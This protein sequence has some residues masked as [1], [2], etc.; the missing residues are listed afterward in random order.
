MLI[1]LMTCEGVNES[2]MGSL[3]QKHAQHQHEGPCQQSMGRRG[4]RKE[5]R[6]GGLANSSSWRIVWTNGIEQYY[7]TRSSRISR[8]E[9]MESE[10]VFNI[11]TLLK[12]HKRGIVNYNVTECSSPELLNCIVF[13][14]PMG[15]N[16]H[17]SYQS[18]NH[19]QSSAVSTQ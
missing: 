3:Q 13:G 5:T 1:A 12:L 11:F 14:A 4:K 15:P 18:I 6:K 7:I 16:M 2:S 10:I 19:F 17:V 9:F 8:K